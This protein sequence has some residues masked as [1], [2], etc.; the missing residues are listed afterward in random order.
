MT[1]A[2]C[3]PGIMAAYES[4]LGFFQISIL[5]ISWILLIADFGPQTNFYVAILVNIIMFFVRLEIVSGLTGLPV[6]RFLKQTFP[7]IIGVVLNSVSI[8]TLFVLPEGFLFLVISLCFILI[9]T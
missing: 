3:A 8:K 7:P 1:T 6:L 4:I 2:A 9:I 5:V